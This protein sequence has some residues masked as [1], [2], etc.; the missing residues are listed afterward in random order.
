MPALTDPV[1]FLKG[2]GP[3]MARR[4]GRLGIVTVRDLLFH[5][6]TG[7][8]DR[9]SLTPIARLTPG[10]EASILA[11]VIEAKLLQRQRGRR[12]LAAT[13]RDET[14]FLRAVWFNQPFRAPLLHPGG[15]YIFSGAVQAFR[16]VELHNPEFEPAEAEREHLH[17]KR[18]VPRYPLTEGVAE[19]WV[20]ARVRDALDGLSPVPDLVPRSWRERLKLPP[21]ATALDEV[22]FPPSHEAAAAARRRLALEELLSVQMALQYARRRHRGRLRARPLGAGDPLMRRFV[23]SL[24]FALTGAQARAIDR[25]AADLDGE[26]PMR[27]LLLGDVGSGKTVVAL[28]AAARA[29]GAGLQAALLAPTSILAEQ[30]AATAERFLAPAGLRVGLLTAASPAAARGRLLDG[31]ASGEIALAIGTHALL[32][33]DLAFRALGLVIVD[34][35]HRFGVR[36]RI[37]LAEKGEAGRGAHLLVLTATP[38]P[39]SLA[40]TL[41]GDLDLSPLDE[42]PPGRV[43]VETAR[44]DGEDRGAVAEVL[45]REI[46]AGGSAFV[47]YPVVE[48]SEAL[49][50]KAA[51]A[52]AEALARVPALAKVGVGLVHGRLKAADRRAALDRFRSGAARVLVA[53]TVVEVGLD[54]PEATLVLI[55]H[56]ERFGLAQL[57]QLRGRVGRAERPGRCV[58]AVARAMGETARRRLAVFQRVNDGFQLAE[59]DLKLRGPGEFLGTSQHGFPELRVADPLLHSDLMEEA[60]TLSIELLESAEREEGEGRLKGW[61]EAHFAGADRYLGSG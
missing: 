11:T 36:Q 25:I 6:P 9:R 51:A 34:E 43:P 10:A 39:R 45:A 1:R 49:D 8:R 50:L 7:Y 30:H 52:M 22:H 21:I 31:V 38:I 58:L 19:R 29:A 3:E 4:L 28:A 42:K 37:S 14:G 35:Q 23:A 18:L 2:V 16:G 27:R 32:E 24:P 54:I 15:R 57:H 40:M 59:E 60:R 12:D 56:P 26:H 48:E 61:I 44:I 47:V 53:T 55:E 46:A 33:Q 13:L 41:Y 17:V 20:R 5:V